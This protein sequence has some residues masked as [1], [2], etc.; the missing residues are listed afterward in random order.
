MR[1]SW[2]ILV[3]WRLVEMLLQALGQ[4]THVVGT[5]DEFGLWFDRRPEGKL[6][7]VGPGIKKPPRGLSILHRRVLPG[8]NKLAH[9]HEHEEAEEDAGQDNNDL[10]PARRAYL[11]RKEAAVNDKYVDTR[12]HEDGR[13]DV[14]TDH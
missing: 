9:V 14:C 7:L 12:D 8:S 3:F 5:L 2:D 6:T 13:G 1:R 4:G 10:P 11:L